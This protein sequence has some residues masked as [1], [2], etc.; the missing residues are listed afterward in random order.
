MIWRIRGRKILF[1]VINPGEIWALLLNMSYTHRLLED[2]LKGV[3]GCV[4]I[5]A[6]Y[7]GWVQMCVCADGQVLNNSFLRL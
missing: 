4:L 7:D 2:V 3:Y 6:G 1:L 5:D